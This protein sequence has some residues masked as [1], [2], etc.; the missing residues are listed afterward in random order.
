M[1]H[2]PPRALGLSSHLAHV[3]L[4]I[5]V[6]SCLCLADGSAREVGHITAALQTLH[7]LNKWVDL[8]LKH[9]EKREWIHV[10]SQLEYE[11]TPEKETSKTKQNKTT[12]KKKIKQAKILSKEK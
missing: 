12:T 10:W 4:P 5:V 3:P 1:L 7:G 9:L 6:A 8:A 2:G 11:S